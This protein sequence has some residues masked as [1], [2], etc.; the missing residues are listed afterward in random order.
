MPTRK[1]VRIPTWLEETEYMIAVASAFLPNEEE[2]SVLTP[3]QV[4]ELYMECP[5][6]KQLAEKIRI[7]SDVM[8][9]LCGKLFNPSLLTAGSGDSKEGV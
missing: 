2:D 9:S 5:F 7:D 1:E 3:E 6:C 4:N 8:C